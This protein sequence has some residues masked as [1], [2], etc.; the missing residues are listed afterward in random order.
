VEEE[1][2]ERKEK[3]EYKKSNE[4]CAK[5]HDTSKNHQL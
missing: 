1:K 3:K 2:K 5:K 4:V